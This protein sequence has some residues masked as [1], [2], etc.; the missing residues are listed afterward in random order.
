MD[1]LTA[2]ETLFLQE[3][4]PILNYSKSYQDVMPFANN[5]PSFTL[6]KLNNVVFLEELISKTYNEIFSHRTHK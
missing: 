2:E 1:N 4:L 5:A 3:I 6:V